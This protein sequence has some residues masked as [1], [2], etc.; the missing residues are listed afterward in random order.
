VSQ[1]IQHPLLPD[2]QGLVDPVGGVEGMPVDELTAQVRRLV[3]GR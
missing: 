3:G 1:A 2:E